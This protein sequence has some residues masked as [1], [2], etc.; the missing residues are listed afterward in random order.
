MDG[1]EVLR[2]LKA[3]AKIAEIPVMIVTVVDEQEMG[4]ALGAVDY[5][6]KPIDRTTL[7]DRLARHVLVPTVLAPSSRVLVI[8]DDP[9]TLELVEASLRIEG[10]EVVTAASGPAGLQIARREEFELI[11]CD[12]VMPGIDGFTVIRELEADPQSP[13]SPIVLFTGHDLTEADYGNLEGR[14][15]GVVHKGEHAQAGLHDWLAW[16]G[17]AHPDADSVAAAPPYRGRA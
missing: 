5:F 7:L 3:D 11:I 12:L 8:D 4:I 15:L 14:V 1:W 16:I 2:R 13:R 6:V 17:G 9:V 10:F